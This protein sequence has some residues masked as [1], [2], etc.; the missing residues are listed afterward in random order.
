MTRGVRNNNPYNIIYRPDV[1]WRGE[2]PY[3]S[4]VE[5]RFCRFESVEY[6]HRAFVKLLFTYSRHRSIDTL[7]KFVDRFCPSTPLV[8][9]SSYKVYLSDMLHLNLHTKVDLLD[10]TLALSEY[11][12]FFESVYKFTD[13]DRDCVLSYLKEFSQYEKSIF[14]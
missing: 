11:V 6:A 9:N 4:L 14:D 8:S 3:D 13:Y 5:S 7:S 2:L 1:H 12:C 10:F